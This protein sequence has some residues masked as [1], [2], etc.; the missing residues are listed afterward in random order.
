MRKQRDVVLTLEKIYYLYWICASLAY[1]HTW[2]VSSKITIFNRVGK[3][4]HQWKT[5]SSSTLQLAGWT[6]HLLTH[7]FGTK[8][9]WSLSWPKWWPSR[10]TGDEHHNVRIANRVQKIFSCLGTSEPFFFIPA[11]W[12]SHHPPSMPPAVGFMGVKLMPNCLPTIG[13]KIVSRNFELRMISAT[14]VSNDTFST[15]RCRFVSYN[16]LSADVYPGDSGCA[17]KHGQ[18][19]PNA[20]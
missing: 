13:V 18:V 17:R 1:H 16:A 15:A 8:R 4:W 2:S 19:Q 5:A 20:P 3:L 9:T 6:G 7:L 11:E 14:W 12:W 10:T